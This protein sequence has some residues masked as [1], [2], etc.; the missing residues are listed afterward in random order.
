RAFT[1]WAVLRALGR[2][3]VAE[4]VNRLC[5]HAAAFGVGLAEIPD[6]TVL[7]DV[8]FTQVCASFGSDELTEAVVRR[9][10]A[11]GT[12]WMSGSTWHDRSVL[13][14]SVSNWSTTDDDVARSLDAVRK[15]ANG[16]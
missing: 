13:R 12:A 7:N 10:L 15:A 14:I 3:G 4:L 16:V 9:L 8:A 2:T 1:V 6:A 5:R 11:E